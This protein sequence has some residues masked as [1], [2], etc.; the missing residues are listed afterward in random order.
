MFIFI[1][2]QISCTCIIT[3]IRN[4]S[5]SSGLHL[6]ML[7][8]FQSDKIDLVILVLFVYRFESEYFTCSKFHFSRRLTHL[9]Y[10]HC[11]E[12]APRRST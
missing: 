12:T 4:I 7:E 9:G 2:S 3:F 10:E 5:D 11:V 1:C 8:H 6:P